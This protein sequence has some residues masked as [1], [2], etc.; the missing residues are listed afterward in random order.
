MFAIGLVW[1]PA[2]LWFD[3]TATNTG[4]FVLGVLTWVLLIAL[5]RRESGAVR[6]QVGI[7]VAF[8]TLI[9]YV[10]SAGLEVYIYRLDHVPPYVPP[11]HG[12]VYLAALTLARS[13]VLRGHARIAVSATVAVASSY[14]VWG[15]VFSPRPDA[16]GAFWC[17]CLVGFLIWGSSRL[18]YVGAFIVVTYLELLGTAWGV[19][20][21]QTHDPTGIVTI[22]NPP[23]VAAGGYGWFDLA[24]VALAPW[25]AAMWARWRAG[26]LRP[27][28]LR[29]ESF[30]RRSGDAQPVHD[31]VVQMGVGG[32]G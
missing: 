23:S 32:D 16:L 29:P 1:I 30:R 26:S 14:A 11:G 17:L 2:V 27:G 12:L 4:Q 24:A 15:L 6:L 28:L 10:F 18:L 31:L 21:W 13:T 8:A 19:W 3:R 20:A 25:L 22:G 7:V 5:L 9:E